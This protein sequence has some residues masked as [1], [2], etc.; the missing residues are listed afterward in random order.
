MSKK[1][2]V[3]K[4]QRQNFINLSRL[5]LRRLEYEEYCNTIVEDDLRAHENLLPRE[6][7][8]HV[9]PCPRHGYKGFMIVHIDENNIAYQVL[10]P[11]TLK[12]MLMNQSKRDKVDWSSQAEA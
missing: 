5:E 12:E 10:N 6:M 7:V 11:E 1:E 8:M 9:L 2:K 4:L 3:F